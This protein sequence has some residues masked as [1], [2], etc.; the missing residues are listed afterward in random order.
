M[1]KAQPKSAFP[2]LLPPALLPQATAGIVMTDAHIDTP[3][4]K[5]LIGF[6][7]YYSP[8]QPIF[9]WILDTSFNFNQARVAPK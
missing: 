3:Q 9:V 5:N 7:T 6:W 2:L 4:Q 1:F 8:A